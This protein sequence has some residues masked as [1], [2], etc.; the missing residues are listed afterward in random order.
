MPL[1]NRLPWAPP[2][3][4]L[5]TALWTLGG[6]LKWTLKLAFGPAEGGG[7]PAVL[8]RELGAPS[9]EPLLLP[10]AAPLVALVG[11]PAWLARLYA[12]PIRR[13]AS[14]RPRHHTQ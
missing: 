5:V 9:S 3:L 13:E 10:T 1:G 6:A 11:V 7:A 14:A 12:P 2:R 4:L 8:Y